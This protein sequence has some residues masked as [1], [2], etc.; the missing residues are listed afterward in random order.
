MR[1]QPNI[2]SIYRHGPQV[3]QDEMTFGRLWRLCRSMWVR[4]GTIVVKPHE[5]PEPLR[6]GMIEWAN[7]Q[8]GGR[9]D[10]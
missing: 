10:R 3:R 5:I 2:S 8:Y 6:A 9:D 4:Q 7:D 1:G